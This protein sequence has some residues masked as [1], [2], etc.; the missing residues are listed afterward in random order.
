MSRERGIAAHVRDEYESFRQSKFE[1]GFCEMLV[2]WVCGAKQNI[3]E[4]SLYCNTDIYDQIWEC[5]LAST[6]AVQA[7]DVR[8][9]FL[10]MSDLNINHQAVAALYFAT[11]SGCDQLVNGL[12]PMYP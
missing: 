10:L 9:S 8:A 4:L 12:I 5:L 3:Y 7:E 2:L 6:A 1:C 11:V